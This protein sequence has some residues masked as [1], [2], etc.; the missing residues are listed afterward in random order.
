MQFLFSTVHFSKEV[1]QGCFPV[2]TAR[3][4]NDGHSVA[5]MVTWWSAPTLP[6]EGS[7]GADTQVSPY[8]MMDGWMKGFDNCV[9]VDMLLRGTDGGEYFIREKRGYLAP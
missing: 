9:I 2:E 5:Q 3:N 1:A 4:E 6:A 8:E 7:R